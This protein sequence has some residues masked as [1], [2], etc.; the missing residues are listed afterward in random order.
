M[1]YWFKCNT[2]IYSQ[3]QIIFLL[4]SVLLLLIISTERQSSQLQFTYPIH[5]FQGLARYWCPSG[6]T[7][8]ICLI[9]VIQLLYPSCVPSFVRFHNI[10]MK[11]F[12]FLGAFAKFRKTTFISVCLSVRPF[13]CP[14]FSPSACNNSAP[15][16]RILMKLGNWVSQKSV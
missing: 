6:V 2:T 3:E 5:L 10:Y 8:G 1:H 4:L 14:S 9:I 7:C 16:G 11:I 13:F 12:V 15:T